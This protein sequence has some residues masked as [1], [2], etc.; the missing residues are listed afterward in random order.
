MAETTLLFETNEICVAFFN[1][2]FSDD[3][4][5]HIEVFTKNDDSGG[6]DD[7]GG[8]DDGSD[9]HFKSNAMFYIGFTEM[10]VVIAALIVVVIVLAIKLRKNKNGDYL[11]STDSN[12]RATPLLQNF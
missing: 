7:G 4:L 1:N 2:Y 12:A 9:K 8:D 5:Y 11:R 3:A 10:G 6:G